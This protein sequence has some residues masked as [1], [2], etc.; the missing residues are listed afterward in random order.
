MEL[1]NSE[2]AVDPWNARGLTSKLQQDGV[3]AV[4]VAQTMANLT[5]APDKACL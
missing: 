5:S 1:A 3:P 4:E 2:V